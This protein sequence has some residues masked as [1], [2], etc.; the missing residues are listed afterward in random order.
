ML[1][2]LLIDEIHRLLREGRL[3]QRKIAARLHVSRGTVSAIASGRRGLFGREPDGDDATTFRPH[4]PPERCPR[5][6]YRVYMPCLV[7]HSRDFQER[8]TELRFAV[9]SLR[10]PITREGAPSQ[11]DEA[12]M[13]VFPSPCLSVFD[14][15]QFAVPV[16]T[17]IPAA[18]MPA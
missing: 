16:L 13:R 10:L 9:E 8:Q 1:A 6:G 2:K 15:P 3:S 12:S 11:R 5:C 7:C 14:P 4:S 18:D 17:L